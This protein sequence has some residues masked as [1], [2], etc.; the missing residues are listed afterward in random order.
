MFIVTMLGAMVAVIRG[1]ANAGIEHL[2]GVPLVVV[3]TLSR[4][5]LDQRDSERVERARLEALAELEAE[6]EDDTRT[7]GEVPVTN[8]PRR[9]TDITAAIRLTSLRRRPKPMT[10]N[11][12]TEREW[13][14]PF[15]GAPNELQEATLQR[16]KARDSAEALMLSRMAHLSDDAEIN[17]AQAALV[18]SWLPRTDDDRRRPEPVDLHNLP[19]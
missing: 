15:S 8:W 16:K 10:S 5:E 9:S 11:E 14:T 13:F 3:S 2:L 6:E 17:E 1:L 4:V 7:L 19:E 12:E 18:H